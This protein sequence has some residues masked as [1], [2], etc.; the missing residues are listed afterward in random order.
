[1]GTGKLFSTKVTVEIDFGQEKHGLY[2]NKIVDENG[3]TITFNSMVDAVNYLS[4]MGWQFVQAYAFSVTA[5]LGGTQTVYHY[6]MR[7]PAKADNV[8]D[9]VPMTKYQYKQTNKN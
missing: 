9:L 4:Q 1:M 7:I 6:L 2:G 5:P 8:G 3:K